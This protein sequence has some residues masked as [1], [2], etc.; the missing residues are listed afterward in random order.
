MKKLLT[1]LCLFAILCVGCLALAL[2]RDGSEPSIDGIKAGADKIL[3]QVT[4]VYEE[5][6]SAAAKQV[7]DALGDKVEQ[8]C[9]T[10]TS[11]RTIGQSKK[12]ST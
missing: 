4:D 7:D 11:G 6:G 5:Y 1:V 2:P 12:A 10:K 3:D 9:R 8:A